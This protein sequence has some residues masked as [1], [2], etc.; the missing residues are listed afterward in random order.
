MV[1]IPLRESCTFS[2]RSL[3]MPD[4]SSSIRFMKRRRGKITSTNGTSRT[5]IQISMSNWL[6]IE[7][8]SL[9]GPSRMRNSHQRT[10][11]RPL[12][13]SRSFSQ[14][15]SSWATKGP[16]RHLKNYFGWNSASWSGK[17][18][19]KC[20]T[21]TSSTCSSI[22][23]SHSSNGIHLLH[24]WCVQ[25]LHLVPSAPSTMRGQQSWEKPEWKAWNTPAPEKSIR[26]AIKEGLPQVL[27]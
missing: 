5:Q 11:R 21:T 25:L 24:V 13:N 19:A 27:M 23:A 2:V 9:C 20:T 1:I 22:S 4:P 10:R 8:S 26:E 16:S 6:R 17:I 15:N 18:I 3:A 12:M 7:Q 14:N